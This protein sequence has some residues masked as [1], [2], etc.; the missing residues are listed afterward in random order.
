MG[1]LWVI[2][3]SLVAGKPRTYILLPH[4]VRAMAQRTEK[5]ATVSYWLPLK[6]YAVDEFE[7]KWQRIRLA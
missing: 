3:N 1:D 7:E 4:E 2:V 5:T 6:K